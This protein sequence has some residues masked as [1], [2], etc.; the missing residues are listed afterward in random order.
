MPSQY[1]VAEFVKAFKKFYQ[2][3]DVRGVLIKHENRWRIICIALRIHIA[4]AKIVKSEFQKLKT[5]YGKIDTPR[6]RIIQQCYSFSELDHL[7]N[8]FLKGHLVLGNLKIQFD[9]KKDILSLRGHIR[10]SDKHAA[11]NWPVLHTS[12]QLLAREGLHQLF[13]GDSEILRDAEVAG[14]YDPY[15]VVAQLLEVDF[16]SST[17]GS[18][19]WVESD[20][21]ARIDSIKASRNNSGFITLKMYVSAHQALS[22]ITCNIRQKRT[23][24]RE[25][26]LKQWALPLKLGKT[27]DNLRKWTGQL[28]FKPDVDDQIEIELV[29]K[30]I[31][32]LYSTQI[33]PMELLRIEE[34]N[35]L[36]TALTRFCSLE[37]VKGLLERPHIV[38]T[39]KNISLKHKGRFYEVSIQWLL[40]SLGLRA[41]WLH[42]YEKMEAGK[43]DYGSIDCLAYHELRNVLL[44]VNCTTA[45][46]NQHEINRQM[47]LQHLLSSE[48]FHNTAVRLYSILFTASHNP[49]GEQGALHGVLHDMNVRIFHR[50]DIPH[51]LGLVEKGQET[52]FI[53]AIINP[54]F[55]NW[56]FK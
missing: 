27:K 31:G 2:T 23:V 6:F 28:E 43:Y 34:R 29:H 48:L 15:S 17:S 40:S 9:E 39:S 4:P 19:L 12:I 24:S 51:L 1:S 16:T 35:P 42:S 26:L 46:P 41:I 10:S 11:M 45:P 37:E 8:G 21:P 14:Y 38:Q 55:S 22:N 49:K 20:I 3:I 7:V 54:A 47:E 44:L 32:R 25:L 50:E 52:K 13:Q 53:D 56:L 18:Y 30:G 5:R 33:R 36:F